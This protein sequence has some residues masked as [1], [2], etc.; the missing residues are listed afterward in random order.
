MTEAEFFS[1]I[2]FR[3]CAELAEARPP[4]APSL[5]CD[6]FVPTAWTSGVRPLTVSGRAWFGG[7]RGHDRSYQETWTFVLEI[8]CD[9]PSVD[10]VAWADLL[11]AEDLHDWFSVDVERRH[12]HMVLH[13]PGE[14]DPRYAG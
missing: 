9:A 4:E 6:G 7:L 2:E 3:L 14:P 12:V 1:H 10:S 13:T 8:H 11:P 5:G